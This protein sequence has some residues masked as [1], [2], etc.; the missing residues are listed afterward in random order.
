MR[1]A[2]QKSMRTT[3][4]GAVAATVLV[5]GLAVAPSARANGLGYWLC[6]QDNQWGG[7]SNTTVGAETKD[8]GSTCGTVGV[9]VQYRTYST[10][11]MYVTGWFYGSS[12]VVHNPNAITV[13]GVH[14][15]ASCGWFYTCGPKNT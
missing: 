5:V 2:S 15:V 3:V 9:A 10:S 12:D 1:R 11:P 14:K 13:G 7:Y 8:V 6:G 4:G